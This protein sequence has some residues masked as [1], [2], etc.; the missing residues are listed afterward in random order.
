[1]ELPQFHAEFNPAMQVFVL[2]LAIGMSYRPYYSKVVATVG[3]TIIF[4]LK[5]RIL[6]TIS[7]VVIAVAACAVH[8]TGM[9]SVTFIPN[10]DLGSFD[11][12]VYKESL[13]WNYVDGASIELMRLHL[14]YRLVLV[15]VIVVSRK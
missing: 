4:F 5:N 15:A 2:I 14:M 11:L 3:V 12:E 13:G 9:Y 7:P 1:M 10:D 6:R 8:Y